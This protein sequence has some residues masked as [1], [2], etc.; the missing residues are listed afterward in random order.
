[1]PSFDII[2]ACAGTLA[3]TPTPGQSLLLLLD[4]IQP[5]GMTNF[6]LDRDNLLPMLG[7]A[8]EHNNLLP[9]QVLES[10]PFHN[11]G[12]TISL[13]SNA[14]YGTP[15][16]RASLLQPD[17]N[18]IGLEIKYGA[19]EALPLAFGQT[20]KLSLQPL[21]RADVGFGPGRGQT[22]TVN[23]GALGVVIDARGRPLQLTSDAVRRRELFKKWLWTLGG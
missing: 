6:M 3:D 11:I 17:K 13:V 16:L 22:V 1:M 10:A 15:I 8:A 23:G 7:V 19:L 18:E 2:I 5:V 12:T 4:A 14:A 20:A 21:H 9:V